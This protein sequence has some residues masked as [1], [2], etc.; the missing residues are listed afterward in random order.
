MLRMTLMLSSGSGGR[1][2]TSLFSAFMLWS[3]SK[4]P[5]VHCKGHKGTVKVG[6]LH[7]RTL[8]PILSL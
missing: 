6:I 2:R 8:P 1:P 4:P 5:R 3:S 7:Y